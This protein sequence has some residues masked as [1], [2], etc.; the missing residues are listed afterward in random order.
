MAEP[1]NITDSQG[2]WLDSRFPTHRLVQPTPSY[3][4]CAESLLAFFK[5]EYLLWGVSC[6]KA[7]GHFA[8]TDGKQRV[9]EDQYQDIKL[10]S[11]SPGPYFLLQ[12]SSCK[13]P[14]CSATFPNSATIWEPSIHTHKPER[15]STH[16]TGSGCSVRYIYTCKCLHFNY[17]E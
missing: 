13:V 4:P 9:N 1:E 2:V 12:G 10:E 6:P 8:S 11:Q 5:C 3:W 15:D 7:A 17:L 16:H 14:R